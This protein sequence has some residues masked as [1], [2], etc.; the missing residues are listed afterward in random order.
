LGIYIVRRVAQSLGFVLVAWLGVYTVLVLLMPG[1]PGQQYREITDNPNATGL[2]SFQVEGRANRYKLDR[3][4]PVNFFTWLFDPNDTIQ[5]VSDPNGNTLQI[6]KGIDMQIGDFRLRGS[7]ILTFDLGYTDSLGR[8]SSVNDLLKQ[9]WGNTALLVGISMVVSVMVAVPLGI[10]AAIRKRS[11]LDH[12]LTFLSFIGFSIPPYMLGVFMVIG[13]AVLPFIWHNQYKLD[14]LPYLPAAFVTDTD[15]ESNLANRMY[16][17][18][19][20][21][22][23]LAVPQIALLSRYVRSSMLEVLRQ[24]YIRTAWAKGLRARRVVLRHAFRNALIPLITMIGVLI[25]GLVSGVILVETVFSYTGMGQ[26]YFRALGGCIV[27]SQPC[28]PTGYAMDYPLALVLTF[29]L[30]VVVAVSNL[31]A[32][33]LYAAADPRIN[34]A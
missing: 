6:P 11:R 21:A 1:G 3:P 2:Q 24:D 32:D 26:L 27:E 8:D 13:L 10:V 22:L 34:Y 23:T 31:I 19:L 29:I 25:P 16:H 4:W 20:P 14:W 15:S 5:F 30:I 9:K 28:P 12:T 33:V 18:V 17:I 7:G